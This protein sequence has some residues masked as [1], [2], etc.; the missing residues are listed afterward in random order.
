[1]KSKPIRRETRTWTKKKKQLTC[2]NV[3]ILQIYLSRPHYYVGLL[4]VNA[5]YLHVCS[6]TEDVFRLYRQLSAKARPKNHS[7][8]E[9]ATG[10]FYV[11][12]KASFIICHFHCAIFVQ[13]IFHFNCI[14]RRFSF[15]P[16]R[17]LICITID[18]GFARPNSTRQRTKHMDKRRRLPVGIVPR[19]MHI[20]CAVPEIKRNVCNLR[21]AT[22]YY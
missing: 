6:C 9:I 13:M 2:Q 12:M 14:S 10:Y 5:F 1:M 3:R 15:W 19:V 18:F 16:F 17:P 4:G 20:S 22:T 11:H 7:A 21:Y 8:M